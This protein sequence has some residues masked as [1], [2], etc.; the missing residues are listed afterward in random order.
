MPNFTVKMLNNIP[1]AEPGKR[2]VYHDDM[3]KGLS[4]RVTEKGVKSFI[5]RKRINGK[6][7]LNTL[8]RYPAM[9]IEQARKKARQTLNSYSAG[10]NPNNEERDSHIKSIT[11]GQTMNDYIHGR[12][13]QLKPKTISDYNILFNRFLSEWANKELKSIT[14]DMVSKKHAHIGDRS[15]YRAN[16]TMRLLRALFNYAAGAYEDSK[17][18]P[19]VVHNPVQRIS[20]NKSWYKE[21]SRSNIIQP[22]DLSKWFDAVKALPENKNN[23]IRVNISNTVSDYLL[24]ILFSG[25]RQSEAAGLLWSDVDFNNKLFTVRDTKNHSDHTL[26][27]SDYLYSLLKTRN[28]NSNGLYVFA[29]ANPNKS[30]VNP[31][32]QIK[33]V[34]EDS[35][36]HF[37]QHDL[38]RTFATIADSLEIQHHIIKR[39]MNHSN[40]DVTSKHYIKPSIETLRKP[41]DK[42]N[43]YILERVE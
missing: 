36:V 15:V 41:M 10:A 32:K 5:I 34:R 25:L 6:L 30:I 17:G 4:L 27:L 37:T 42:I 24:F 12:N 14:R 21:T 3:V 23:G 38:R 18:E 11:L 31:Y 26:P 28:L 39:L 9:T 7:A 8:G 16:A 22:N 33:K 2:P 19:I 13:A 20:H 43:N 1:N 40:N 35:G 29:G